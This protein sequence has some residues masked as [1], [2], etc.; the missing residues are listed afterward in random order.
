MSVQQGRIAARKRLMNRIRLLPRTLLVLA[1]GALLAAC[2]GWSPKEEAKVETDVV[3][4][5]EHFKQ[6]D[7]GLKRFFDNA[8]GYAVF[9]T[10]GKGAI[11]IGGAYGKGQ[12]F[13]KGRLVGTSKLAQ[14]TI[15]FQLG[16]QAYS[17]LIFFEDKAAL[18]R[19]KSGNLEFSAQASAVAI[20]LGASA[21]ADYE[22]GVAVFTMTKG[23]LM[24][25]ASIGGQSFSFEAY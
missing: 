17:E 5:V 7:P 9:P 3:E 15:G 24:Y 13:E 6:R 16:G 21:T 19:F 12:V 2:S 10:V 11:G 25:E 1:L 14:L 20:T 23:G 18:D 22:G 8:Y 4:T